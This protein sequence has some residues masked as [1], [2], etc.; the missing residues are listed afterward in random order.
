[1][2]TY[3]INFEDEKTIKYEYHPE[4][5]EEDGIIS[6]DKKTKEMK[7]EKKAYDDVEHDSF[8]SVMM[9]SKIRK[10]IKNNLFEKKGI[11]I[12]Y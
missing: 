10:F 2:L 1:M 9:F 8:F 7:H 12:W 6:Y 3:K 4:D 11:V 5:R